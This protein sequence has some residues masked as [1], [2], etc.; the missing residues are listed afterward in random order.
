[1]ARRTSWACDV[2]GVEIE[3]FTQAPI[4]PNLILG[5]ELGPFDRL[6][7]DL[8]RCCL[9]LLLTW[10]RVRPEEAKAAEVVLQRAPWPTGKA[11]IVDG[12]P[13]PKISPQ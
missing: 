6:E 10:L 11:P 2:C 8:C 1:M 13:T 3:R 9:D 7:R 5:P 12:P 4:E